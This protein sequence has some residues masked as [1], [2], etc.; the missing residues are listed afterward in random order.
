[1]RATTL[2]ARSLL[3]PVVLIAAAPFAA[4][5]TPRKL[6]DASLVALDAASGDR[7]GDAVA[8]EGSRAVVGSTYDD[9][10]GTNSGSAYVFE[11]AGGVWT[12]AAKLTA[13]DGNFEDWF[14]AAVALSGDTIAVGASQDDD[15]GLLSSGS[16]YVFERSGSAWVETAKLHAS[17]HA[18]NTE[19]G[20]SVALQADT[21]VVGAQRAGGNHGAAYVFERAGGAWTEVARLA[22]PTLEVND[23]FGVSVALDG[24][25]LAVGAQSYNVPVVDGGAVFVYERNGG[26]WSPTSTLVAS[27]GK[28]NDR[29]G[30]S[31]ALDGARILVGAD[32]DELPLWTGAGSAYVFEISAGSWSETAHLSSPDA[33]NVEYFGNS[34]A[35]QGDRALIGCVQDLDVPTLRAGAAYLFELG[36][37]GWTP[38]FKAVSTVPSKSE[39]F[40]D[41]VAL[42]GDFALVGEPLD[43]TVGVGTFGAAQVLDLRILPYGESC[44]G[45]VSVLAPQL[46]AWGSVDPGGQVEF[47]VSH[48]NPFAAAFVAF[49][50]TEIYF[51]IGSCA[52][53]VGPAPKA[54][55]ITLGADGTWNTTLP[56]TGLVGLTLTFQVAPLHATAPSG[57]TTTNGI[58]LD[59][60]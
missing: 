20:V 31:V 39:D 22:P 23:L 54:F 29:F 7:F 19:F 53:L 43:F 26:L 28:K 52:L 51:P 47:R 45:T 50:Q 34:V 60:P 24:D 49:G 10:H 9:D 57:F 48:G 56:M 27:D 6:P 18:F 36:T 16:V 46:L 41:A 14:G 12:Q 1:M 5:E 3:I 2:H 13:S 35:L 33:S 59:V 38:R 4:A 37:G 17:D 30:H 21:L 40:G 11:R 44:T 32:N 8:L 42:D 25:R 58:R 15:G 55:V